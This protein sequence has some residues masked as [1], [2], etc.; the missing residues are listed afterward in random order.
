MPVLRDMVCTVCG[1]VLADVMAEPRAV[2][3]CH[4]CGRQRPFRDQCNGGTKRRYRLND[5]PSD[6]AFWRGQSRVLG[7]EVVDSE[8]ETVRRY[9]SGSREIGEPMAAAPQYRNGSD[10]RE[11][12]RDIIRSA[13]DRKLGTTPVVLDMGARHE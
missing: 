9:H 1:V 5:W 2:L 13:T 4:N 11:T 7:A 10:E 6:P 3:E 8:G 12:R